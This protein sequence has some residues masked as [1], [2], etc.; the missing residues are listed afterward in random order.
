MAFQWRLLLALGKDLW[1]HRRS[2]RV[3]FLRYHDSMIA[4]LV[5]GFFFNFQLLIR[6][7][8]VLPNL[9]VYDKTPGYF[10]YHTIRISLGLLIRRAS[11]TITVTEQI[12]QWVIKEY[13]TPEAKF[14]ILPNAVDTNSFRPRKCERSEWGV[15][16]NDPLMVFVG[17][18]YNDSGLDTVLHAMANLHRT[19]STPPHFLILGDGPSLQKLVGLSKELGIEQYAHWAGFQS[20]DRVIAAIN[21]SDICLAPFP[22]RVFEVTGSSSLKLFEYLACDRPI[23]ASRADDHAFIERESLGQLVEPEN[24]EAWATALTSIGDWSQSLDG[25]GRQFALN[26]HSYAAAA[27]RIIAMGMESIKAKRR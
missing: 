17:L 4:P 2:E 25:R 11:K 8:P 14:E 27:S 23:F 24:T 19:G 5:L 15:P 7:G 6:T 1:K 3:V 21:A 13:G 10:V 12:K 22:R 9:K 26:H 18:I 20:R 16:Q